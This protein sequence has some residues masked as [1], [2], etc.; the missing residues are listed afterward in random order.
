MRGRSLT[1]TGILAAIFAALLLLFYQKISIMAI[2]I[3]GGILFVAVGLI[4]LIFFGYKAGENTSKVLTFITNA[5]A[6][7]LGLSMLVFRSEFSPMISF[8]MG[9]IVAVSSLWQFFVLAIGARPHQLPVWLYIFPVLLAGGA[10][11]IYLK[12]DY[13]D[14]NDSILLLAT[15]ISMAVFGAGCIIEGSILGMAR[16]N[17]LKAQTTKD[18]TDTSVSTKQPE[19]DSNR[20]KDVYGEPRQIHN[21]SET[22]PIT[23]NTEISRIRPETT[24]D[25]DDEINASSNS[26]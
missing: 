21:P 1:L 14:K 24:E 18:Q 6:I 2:T 13:A 25:L 23:P 10:I 7:V 4:N 9:L 22:H 15:G 3:S 8:M 12:P 5:A 11:Y 17:D 19:I 20:Q 16:R 26:N